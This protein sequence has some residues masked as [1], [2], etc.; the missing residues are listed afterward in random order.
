MA[1]AKGL[2][3]VLILLK[4]PDPMHLNLL[5]FREVGV[6]VVL[7]D[8]RNRWDRQSSAFSNLFGQADRVDK[9]ADY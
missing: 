7:K 9:L 5:K 3:H 2:T 4:L 6:E 1:L 8:F